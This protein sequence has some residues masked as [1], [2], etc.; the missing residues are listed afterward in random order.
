MTTCFAK[1][2]EKVIKNNSNGS[3]IS[4]NLKNTITRSRKQST[5]KFRILRWTGFLMIPL[6]TLYDE[7]NVRSKLSEQN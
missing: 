6:A 7:Y 5:K 3:H 1:S 4:K 2:P